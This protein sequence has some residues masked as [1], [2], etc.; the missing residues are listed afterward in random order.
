MA[1][2]SKLNIEV[3]DKTNRKID[4]M[5]VTPGDPFMINPGEF[6]FRIEEDGKPDK[7]GMVACYSIGSGRIN[8][9]SAATKVTPIYFNVVATQKA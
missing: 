7:L 9:Y 8:I 3:H 6:Y 5:D 2:K 1:E 4:L